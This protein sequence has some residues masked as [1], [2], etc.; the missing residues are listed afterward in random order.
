MDT[1]TSEG[2]V[3]AGDA[4][5]IVSGVS[6]RR[7]EHLDAFSASCVDVATAA[8]RLVDELTQAGYF[9]DVH[10]STE[11]F[12][13]LTVMSGRWRRTQLRVE[14]GRDAQLFESVSSPLGP[15]L[16]IRELAANK[17]LAAFGRHE[18]RDL[19]DLASIAAV[20]SMSEAFADAARKDTGFDVDVLREMVIRTA[21]VRDDLWPLGSDPDKVRAFI[22]DV[23]LVVTPSHEAPDHD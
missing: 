5:L 3:I 23:L 8:D 16:S 7:T 9:V 18:P 2:F 22:A 10:R 19:V 11:S 17:V 12:A 1:I 14:L 21:T 20:T 4:A 15:M 13:Q 6:E